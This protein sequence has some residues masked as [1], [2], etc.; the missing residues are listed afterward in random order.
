MSLTDPDLWRGCRVFLTGHTGFKGG[1]LA[2]W[3]L[4]MGAEVR[5]FSREVPPGP[6]FFNASGLAEVAPG[7]IGDICDT[8]ALV[9]A[10]QEFEPNLILHLAAQ[11]LVRHSYA[12][13]LETFSTNV[14]G[15]LHVLEAVRMTPAVKATV[16]VTTDKCYEN[17]EWVWGYRED[18]PMGGHD[19]YSASKGCAELVAASYRRSFL[20]ERGTFVATARAG[21]VLGGGDWAL[22]RIVPDAI[23]SF[24]DGRP[25]EVRSPSA[26]RPW[27]HVLEPLSGYLML[28]ERLL[29]GDTTAAGAWNFGPL[30]DSETTVGELAERLARE[31]SDG[32]HWAN[33]EDPNAPHEAETLRLDITKARTRLG[34]LPLLKLDEAI[35]WT[36]DWYKA[37]VSNTKSGALY[38]LTHEQIEDYVARGAPSSRPSSRIQ[39]TAIGEFA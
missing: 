25:L 9:R 28:A 11:S 4:A 27:Q 30:P 33:Q 1:W 34:W 13:P 24:A 38:D 39:N 16:I 14:M 21:N 20:A 6:N 12:A 35:K 23:R 10:V 36:V 22:D 17:Q 29:S 18:D 19:P 2:H 15:T 32:A 3:L 31:W 37:A 8:E 26:V 5:G 7:I